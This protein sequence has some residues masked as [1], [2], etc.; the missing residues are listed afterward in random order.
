MLVPVK[1]P[2]G[3]T[4]CQTATPLSVEVVRSACVHLV[5]SDVVNHTVKCAMEFVGEPF[6]KPRPRHD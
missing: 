4:S 5:V 3:K 6:S 2:I 1:C